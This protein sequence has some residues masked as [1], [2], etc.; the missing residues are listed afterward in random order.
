MIH[1]LQALR[2][3]LLKVAEAYDCYLLLICRLTEALKVSFC[4]SYALLAGY[5][6]GDKYNCKYNC[7]PKSH[8]LVSPLLPT[9]SDIFFNTENHLHATRNRLPIS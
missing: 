5:L 7:K 4:Y 9:L 2:P 6:A 8:E 1:L 3:A